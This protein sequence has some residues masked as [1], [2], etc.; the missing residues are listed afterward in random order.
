MVEASDPWLTDTY[1]PRS[2]DLRRRLCRPLLKLLVWPRPVSFAEG[3]KTRRARLGQ[4]PVVRGCFPVVG[5]SDEGVGGLERQ[6]SPALALPCLVLMPCRAV[7][8]G[9]GRHFA[10]SVD[11]VPVEVC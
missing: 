7:A 5:G 3:G 9:V 4:R 10:D 6:C 8:A 1:V 2:S 11:G